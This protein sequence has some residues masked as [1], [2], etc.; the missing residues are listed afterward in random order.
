MAAFCYTN[1]FEVATLPDYGQ[2]SAEWLEAMEGFHSAAVYQ[3]RVQ[4]FLHYHSHQQE[5]DASERSMRS[6][7]NPFFNAKNAE[8]NPNGTRK[9][10][11]TTLRGVLSALKLYWKIIFSVHDVAKLVPIIETHL[12]RWEHAQAP[13]KKAKTLDDDDLER[14][15]YSLIRI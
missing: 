13:P 8:K 10:K 2:N 1:Q 14:Y 6:S 9:F 3:A 7:L 15:F 12:K 5:A 11:S 4:E